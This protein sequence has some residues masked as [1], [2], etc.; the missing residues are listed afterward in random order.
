MDNSR[1]G[2][3]AKS[4]VVTATATV[5]KPTSQVPRMLSALSDSI[6]A[7]HDAVV[8]LCG[9]LESAGALVVALPAAPERNVI[10]NDGLCP[11]SITVVEYE[12]RVRNLLYTV[13]AV[14]NRLAL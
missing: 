14:R 3:S 5:S 1:L 9:D 12:S 8:A 10:D 2:F 7:L 4:A 11:L 6:E 13:D